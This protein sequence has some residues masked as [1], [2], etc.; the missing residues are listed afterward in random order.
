MYFMHS[1]FA[2]CC[3]NA[4]SRFKSCKNVQN[5]SYMYVLCCESTL[6]A[7]APSQAFSPHKTMYNIACTLLPCDASKWHY[8][9]VPPLPHMLSN[10]L[11]GIPW[12]GSLPRT[13]WTC[14]MSMH[15]HTHTQ[16]GKDT[17]DAKH[18][19]KVW[20]FLYF[21]PEVLE[22]ACTWLPGTGQ[23]DRHYCISRLRIHTTWTQKRTPWHIRELTCP[24]K[25]RQKI[26][27]QRIGVSTHT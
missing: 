1:W 17:A 24:R 19:R 10:P 8:M 6:S 22:N 2:A 25:C 14:A 13:L 11:L 18:V 15:V 9:H 21:L 4:P 3:V 23:V 12:K 7:Y 26:G 5:A 16:G 27:L 20:C